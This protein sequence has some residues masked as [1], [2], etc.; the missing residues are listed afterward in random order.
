M[1]I[2]ALSFLFAL[3]VPLIYAAVLDPSMSRAPAVRRSDNQTA[4]E[5]V[6]G[7]ELPDGRHKI[8]FYLNGV[9][10]GSAIETSDG[11]LWKALEPER[12]AAKVPTSRIF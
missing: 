6:V 2:T 4:Y 12:S 11:G 9:L 1:K 10:E 8:D 3:F 5:D 7:Y